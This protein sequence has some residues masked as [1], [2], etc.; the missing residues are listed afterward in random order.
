ML[1]YNFD[2]THPAHIRFQLPPNLFM[3]FFLVLH[4]DVFRRLSQL[5]CMSGDEEA[6]PER[7]IGQLLEL[8]YG[9]TTLG[10]GPGPFSAMA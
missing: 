5:T 1:K 2:S 8:R 4:F 7:C 9:A 6:P 3:R 10:D